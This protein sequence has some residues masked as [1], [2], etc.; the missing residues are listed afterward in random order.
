[1]PGQAVCL[2]PDFFQELAKKNRFEEKQKKLINTTGW[3]I[4]RSCILC[5]HCCLGLGRS[6]ILPQT[7][8]GWEKWMKKCHLNHG[9]SIILY[10]HLDWTLHIS[11]LTTQDIVQRSYTQ[12][13]KKSTLSHTSPRKERWT[14]MKTQLLLLGF[15]VLGNLCLNSCKSNQSMF[16]G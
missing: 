2:N 16:Q 1:M 7:L 15:T 9:K 4:L 8:H 3:K 5:K 10:F 14:K 13:K 6:K 11:C 12:G